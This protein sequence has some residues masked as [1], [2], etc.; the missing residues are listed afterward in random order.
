M[1]LGLS[2]IEK[3]AAETLR[4]EVR[5]I[6]D[7]VRASLD[8]VRRIAIE[9]RPEA[10]DDLGLASALAVLAQRLSERLGFEVREDIAADLSEPR[11]NSSCIGWRRKP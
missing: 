5:V 8:D 1:L 2:R 10:L 11:R 9:L 7:A 6:Q 4:S 3:E